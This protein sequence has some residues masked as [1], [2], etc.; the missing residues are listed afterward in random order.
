MK[1]LLDECVT[2]KLIPFLIGHEVS[3]VSQ[4]KW[5]GLKNGDLIA[6]AEQEGFEMLLTVDKKIKYQNIISKYKIT[7]VIINTSSSAIETISKYIPVLL[8]EM[9]SFESGNIYFIDL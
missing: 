4:K 9:K 7:I 2:K 8:K 6:K 5:N 1:I 3:T